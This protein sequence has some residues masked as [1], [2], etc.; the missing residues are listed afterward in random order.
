MLASERP[1]DVS[2]W[3]PPS[4]PYRSLLVYYISKCTPYLTG[5]LPKWL[6]LTRMGV[7][8]HNPKLHSPKL[9]TLEEVH[10]TT[11]LKFT[12]CYATHQYCLLSCPIF[13]FVIYN[14]GNIKVVPMVC[15]QS[16]K[17]PWAQDHHQQCSGKGPTAF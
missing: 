4:P 10:P 11:R 17:T 9:L 12:A 5:I 6:L 14:K 1:T 13:V 7:W 16:H 3:G 8:L 15:S 2:H